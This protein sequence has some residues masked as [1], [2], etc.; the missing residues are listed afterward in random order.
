MKKIIIILLI[1]MILPIVNA[2]ICTDT[3]NSNV[4]VIEVC[5]YCSELNGSICST[6]Q[7][8]ITIYYSNFSSFVEN[9]SVVNNGEGNLL[10][11]ITQD[12]GSGLKN[13]SDGRYFG[14]FYC[15]ERSR[16]NFSFTISTS[17]TG[18][19]SGYSGRIAGVDD[20]E[21][22]LIKRT[23]PEDIE[24]YIN[25]FAQKVS[26][27]NKSIGKFFFWSLLILLLFSQE[28]YKLIKKV[29]LKKKF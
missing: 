7:C 18:Y 5:G 22:I 13:L 17:A 24:Y 16:E 26:P 6:R 21:I 14:E 9:V 8:N 10:Y 27:S 1:C 11:N 15:G 29:R 3:F 25:W 19:T 20:E 4:D 28:I 2:V 23:I 12:L